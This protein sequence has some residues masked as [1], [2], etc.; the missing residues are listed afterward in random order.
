MRPSATHLDLTDTARLAS[1]DQLDDE[2]AGRIAEAH[3]VGAGAHLT[4]P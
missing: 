3:A 4:R 1:L 2:F